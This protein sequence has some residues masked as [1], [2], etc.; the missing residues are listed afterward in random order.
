MSGMIDQQSSMAY[1]V[2]RRSLSMKGRI[3]IEQYAG[4]KSTD[5]QGRN[6]TLDESNP[7]HGCQLISES[8]P[9]VVEV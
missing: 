1:N 8:L 4:G 2:L 6:R 5:G 9:V 3:W 7:G